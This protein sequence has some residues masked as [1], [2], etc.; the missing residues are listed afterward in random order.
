MALHTNHD[1]G[2]VKSAVEAT[3]CE[4]NQVYQASCLLLEALAILQTTS[5]SLRQTQLHFRDR[6]IRLKEVQSLTGLCR[7]SIYKQIQEG[8]F[9]RSVKVGARATAWSEKS[10]REWI[11]LQM[12]AV[13][14]QSS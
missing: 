7:S 6:L 12:V 14:E 1:I 8:V 10:I 5:P 2:F 11:R 3:P 13:Q 9:P 4:P